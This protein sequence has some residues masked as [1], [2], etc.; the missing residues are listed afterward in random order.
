MKALQFKAGEEERLEHE[1]YYM[2]EKMLQS[3]FYFIE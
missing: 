3:I 2:I 1:F